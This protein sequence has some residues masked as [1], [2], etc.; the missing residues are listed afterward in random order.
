M[1]QNACVERLLR[2]DYLEAIFAGKCVQS[3]GAA[4]LQLSHFPLFIYYFTFHKRQ[5]II[6]GRMKLQNED[7]HNWCPSSCIVIRVI[8]WKE[9]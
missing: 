9:T 7:V 3:S 8:K 6:R 2:E 1:M 5:E 4:D